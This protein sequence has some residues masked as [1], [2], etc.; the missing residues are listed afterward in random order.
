MSNLHAE[1]VAQPGSR[2]DFA[3]LARDWL[4]GARRV[5]FPDIDRRLG[6]GGTFAAEPPADDDAPW[7]PPGGAWARLRVQQQPHTLGGT[8][9]PYSAR[10]W[11]RMLDGLERSY[12][13]HVSLELM[14]LGPDGR[15]VSPGPGAVIAVHRS[16]THPRWA[17]FEAE[18]PPD[19]AGWRGS[20]PVQ[21]AWAGFLKEQAMA[22][23]AHYGHVTDDANIHATA[24]ERAILGVAAEPPAVPHCREVL[25]GYSWVTVC[26]AEL[27]ARLGGGAALA[28]SGCFDEVSVLPGGQVFLRATPALEDYDG[29]AVQR[30]F[31]ALAPV[32]LPGRPDPA[33]VEGTLARIVMDADAAELGCPE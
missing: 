6:R 10:M 22:A 23:G 4:T 20:A 21:L 7:G 24:L 16:T 26:A 29:P 13:F 30:V 18:A 14:P 31:G 8:V 2:A 25:R 5:L 19:L 11:R 17:R 3:R 33:A 32:L 15:P 12:P 1:L 27:A 9:M 28:A